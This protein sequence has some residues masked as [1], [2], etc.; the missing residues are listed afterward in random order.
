M[1]LFISA[2]I[3]FGAI[4]VNMVANIVTPTYVIQLFTKLNY[5][6]AVTI[7]GLLAM[8]SFPWVLVQDDNAKGLDTFVHVYS[9]FLGPMIAILVI[10]FY[11]LRKQHIDIEELYRKG[12]DFSGVNYAAIIA[13]IVGAAAAFLFVDLAWLIGFI[14]AAIVYPLVTK[15]MFKGSSFKNNTI[16]DQTK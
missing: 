16:F 10:E 9:A 5:K 4:A 14:V 8:G 15:Y 7:T 11:V 12:G 3:V 6:V 1:Q 2:F 13:L